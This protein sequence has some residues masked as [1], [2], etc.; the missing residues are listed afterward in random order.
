MPEPCKSDRCTG[1]LADVCKAPT[2]CWAAI[3]QTVLCVMACEFALAKVLLAASPQPTLADWKARH[4]VECF[5]PRQFGL[6]DLV[7]SKDLPNSEGVGGMPWRLLSR[8]EPRGDDTEWLAQSFWND[9]TQHVRQVALKQQLNLW[10]MR[11][12]PAHLKG[13]CEL[14]G[15]EPPPA[16]RG[17]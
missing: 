9:S 13:I 2:A 4:K 3:L 10:G 5:G 16:C 14:R 12:P 8:G 17:Y 7:T 6:Y 1:M 11:L 15:I